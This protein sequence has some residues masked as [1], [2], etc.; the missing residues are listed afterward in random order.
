MFS[1]SVWVSLASAQ[2][3][4]D[5][6]SPASLLLGITSQL[7]PAGRRVL[8]YSKLIFLCFAKFKN[9]TLCSVPQSIWPL[10]A[11]KDKDLKAGSSSPKSPPVSTLKSSRFSPG[12]VDLGPQNR[13]RISLAHHW[14]PCEPTPLGIVPHVLGHRCPT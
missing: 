4:S 12:R 10:G 3:V 8:F 14:V 2:S 5:L 9:S 11:V 7:L 1:L 6:R 13:Q